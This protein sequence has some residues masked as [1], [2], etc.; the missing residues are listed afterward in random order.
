MKQYRCTVCGWIYDPAQMN[1]EQS[2]TVERDSGEMPEDFRC[3]RCGVR[4]D[5]FEPLERE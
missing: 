4:K 1:A 5:L 2:A 3:P